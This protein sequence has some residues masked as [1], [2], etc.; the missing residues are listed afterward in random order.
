MSLK[1]VPIHVWPFPLWP[2]ARSF[3]AN[4]LLSPRER[5]YFSS[6]ARKWM[7]E[8]LSFREE[9]RKPAKLKS[10]YF[11][12]KR[13]RSR[14]LNKQL[15]R[16]E[17]DLAKERKSG[18]QCRESLLAEKEGRKKSGSNML[19]MEEKH[20]HL[21]KFPRAYLPSHCSI[22][23]WAHVCVILINFL[24]TFFS[25]QTDGLSIWLWINALCTFFFSDMVSLDLHN[26]LVLLLFFLLLLL[27]GMALT[28]LHQRAACFARCKRGNINKRRWITH[29]YVL[30][31]SA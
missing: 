27:L 22:R 24:L 7:N 18:K 28:A 3:A 17:K 9:A 29:S 19:C 5:S 15:Q 30:N 6:Y 16:A 13:N 2:S 21:S 10:S 20:L 25:Q 12:W 26:F 1:R 23:M 4:E 14:V 8:R 31:M 11:P